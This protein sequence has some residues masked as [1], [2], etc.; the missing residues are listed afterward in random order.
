MLTALVLGWYLLSPGDRPLR[1]VQLA[2]LFLPYPVALG[3]WMGQI[4]SFQV[5]AIAFCY[6]LLRRGRDRSAGM[7]LAAIA[8][9]PQGLFLVP[10]ALLIAGKRRVFLS[11][12]ACMA[13]IGL[14]VLAFIGANGAMAYAQRILYAQAH[15]QEFWVNWS[16]TLLRRFEGGTKI[17]VQLTV[18]AAAML[19]S[20]R[21][22]K[23][24]ELVIA[25][26]ILGSLL[27][28]PFVHLDDFVLLFPAAWLVLRASPSVWT[29]VFLLLGYGALYLCGRDEHVW[30]RWVLLFECLWLAWL[31]AGRARSG[32]TAVLVQAE[33]LDREAALS[34][35]RGVS[36]EGIP[37]PRG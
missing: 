31:A 29:A 28:T 8:L 27:V 15:P 37:P 22:R 1:G 14:V 19:A 33:P 17:L 10:F 16:Y 13:A 20:F 21:N 23:S 25:A 3:L 24:T 30:A 26:G 12:L 36:R 32:P 34:A 11:W 6:V 2:M 4:V 5:A 18:A 9:K 7:V 35:A